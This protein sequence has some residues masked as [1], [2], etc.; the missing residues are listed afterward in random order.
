[1][2]VPHRR[3]HRCSVT[4]NQIHVHTLYYRVSLLL[5]DYWQDYRFE[6]G[7]LKQKD[8]KQTGANLW[9]PVLCSFLFSFL[10]ALVF[11][12]INCK[13]AVGN[14]LAWNDRENTPN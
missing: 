1:M 7:V 5:T 4:D 13:H 9:L 14:R 3:Y 6:Q 11:V 12:E 8:L 2:H 10:F